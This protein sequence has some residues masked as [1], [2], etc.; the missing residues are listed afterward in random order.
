MK[1][2]K[3]RH[4]P[5]HHAGQK[6][7]A[8]DNWAPKTEVENQRPVALLFPASLTE[9]TDGHISV[10]NGLSLLLHRPQQKEGGSNCSMVDLS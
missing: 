6:A 10:Q 1:T 9:G 3:M 2:V 5:P 8:I 4:P 7:L